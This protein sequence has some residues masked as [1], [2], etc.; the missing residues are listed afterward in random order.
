MQYRTTVEGTKAAYWV[1]HTHQ[2]LGLLVEV[3]LDATRVQNL[4]RGYS[5]T[6][7]S[8]MLA[9]GQAAARG[10]YST[11]RRLKELMLDNPR[12]LIRLG[13]LD[14]MI[15]ELLAIQEDLADERNS[16]TYSP[17]DAKILVERGLALADRMQ[18]VID[19]MRTEENQLLVGRD[20]T[21]SGVAPLAIALAGLA[22]LTTLIAAGFVFFQVRA[23]SWAELQ[24]RQVLEA[25]PDAVVVIDQAGSMVLVNSQLEK[26][27]GYGRKELLGQKVEM[28][29][30]ERFRQRHPG[31]RTNFFAG[32]H[33]RPMG[34]GLD[35]Y[36]QRSDGTEFPVEI[37]LSP[38]EVGGAVLV[39][40]AIRD[41]TEHKLVEG[42]LRAQ[43]EALE[44]R[45]SL[46]DIADDAIV[47]REFGG[48]IHFWS[49]G[50]EAFY[51]GA[52]PR[53]S[54]SLPTLC[55]KH[56]TRSR[57]RRLK[58]RSGWRDDGQAN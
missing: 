40:A 16:S 39:S 52:R 34:A 36:G 22:I 48:Q 54:A 12:Q 32:A 45:A 8:A 7:D 42:Q 6:G 4:G 9:P 21:A 11:V 41:I 13:S 33:A 37:S 14:P 43:A 51:G 26:L 20:Q 2:V 1:A 15:P 56:S 3:S 24:F 31:Q 30:P 44:E 27:F 50:A 23:L 53:R 55:F 35:L 57:S 5:L 19:E 58:P 28:L 46:L 47:V 25:A 38:L 17:A 10:L 49:R 29:T 18:R